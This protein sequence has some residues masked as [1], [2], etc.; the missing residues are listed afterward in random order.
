MER[1]Q[2]LI[3]AS[4]LCSRRQA[5]LWIQQGRVLCNGETVLL[6]QSADPDRDVILVDGKPLP[7]RQEPVYL[8]LHKPKGYVTTLSD[9]KG[10][11]DVSALV[12]DCGRRVYPVGRL[13]MDSEGLLLFTD[14]GAFAELLTHPRHEVDK[15]YHVWVGQFSPEGLERLKKPIWLDGYQIHPPR[16]HILQRLGQEQAVLE[17]VIHEGRNRQVRRMC[18]RAG[19]PVKR[20]L[21][22]AEGPLSLGDLPVG[23]W[24]YLSGEEVK[25]LTA[26]D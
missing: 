20:L 11:R 19:M 15:R 2:K 25:K 1:I 8:M 14:D 7:A 21:R 13:D 9:E 24:R 17:V 22:V 26:F 12:R 3:A 10:R 5:E 23:K 16:V 6:G 4:G 18:A